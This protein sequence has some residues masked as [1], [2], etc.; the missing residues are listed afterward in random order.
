MTVRISLALLCAALVSILSACGGGT[1]LERN[2]SA[3]GIVVCKPA[4]GTTAG[5]SATVIYYDDGSTS[6]NGPIVSWE[7]NFG[8]GWQD[9]TDTEGIC[10]HTYSGVGTFPA[11]L[12]VT[13]STGQKSSAMIKTTLS[14]GSNA[15]PIF[16]VLGSPDESFSDGKGSDGSSHRYHNWRWRCISYDPEDATFEAPPE[17]TIRRQLPPG[18]P[19]FDLLVCKSDGSSSDFILGDLD[20]DGTND[21]P[22]VRR[23]FVLPHVLE[24][25]GRCLSPIRESPTIFAWKVKP[26]A[27]ANGEGKKEYVGH[28]SLLK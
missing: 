23:V 18:D 25:S 6:T 22:S 21:D 19:D 17:L 5:R 1:T 11:H 13:D 26:A 20:G 28:V 9:A 14:D 2:S 15:D 12:R 27:G 8:D 16:V 3:R 10:A 4:G 7:W 24:V